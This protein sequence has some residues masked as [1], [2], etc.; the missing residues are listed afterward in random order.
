MRDA[1]R[2]SVQRHESF[3]GNDTE[4]QSVSRL[5]A[6]ERDGCV[7]AAGADPRCWYVRLVP[8]EAGARDWMIR[9]DGYWSR[10]DGREI[11]FMSY[12]ASMRWS[13]A[14]I[15]LSSLSSRWELKCRLI[16]FR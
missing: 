9:A 15:V 2:L 10:V 8:G 7:V 13:P 3:I 6:T 5:S 12:R 4:L 11:L 1:D 16:P 14:W